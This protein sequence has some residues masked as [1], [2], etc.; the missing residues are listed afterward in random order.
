EGAESAGGGFGSIAEREHRLV[1]MRRL[2]SQDPSEWLMYQ[3]EMRMAEGYQRF[4]AEFDGEASL[5]GLRAVVSSFGALPGRKSILYFTE[6]LPIPDRQKAKFDALIGEANRANIV[7]YPVDAVGLRVQSK[8]AELSR[9]VAVAGAK[10]I[11][12]ESRGEGAWTKELEK[13]DEMLSSRPT[14]VLGRLAKETGGFLLE[15]TNDLG[16]GVARM[17]QDR[18]TYYLLA[19]QPTNMK[20]DGTFR[21]VTVKVKRPKVT[22]RARPG[23]VAAHS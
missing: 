13:Q 1:E 12:D 11:G 20:L 5:A 19:Y 22:V 17:Q 15:N 9:N 3:I 23:Y 16:A 2:G 4:L 8:D 21:K 6:K 7:V 14:A 18:T 10:G